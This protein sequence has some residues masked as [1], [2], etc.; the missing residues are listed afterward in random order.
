MS[1]KITVTA[2]AALVTILLVPIAPHTAAAQES[3]VYPW[4]TA[5]GE[6]GSSCAFTSYEQCRRSARMCEQN[7]AYGSAYAASP[8][9]AASVPRKRIHR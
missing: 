6:G 8:Y 3:R 4:C 7:P 9:A 1:T 2:V 5:N